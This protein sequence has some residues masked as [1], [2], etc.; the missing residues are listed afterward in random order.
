MTWLFAFVIVLAAGLTS[1][2]LAV[3]IWQRRSSPGALVFALLMLAVAEWSVGYALEIAAPGEAAKLLWAKAQYLGIV[4]VPLAWL[5]FAL[6]YS[7]RD[8]ALTGHPLRIA[9]LCTVPLVTLLLVWTNEA[10]HLVWA[11]AEVHQDGPFPW[12]HVSYGVWFWVHVAFSYA[13][14]LGGTVSLVLVL[15]RSPQLYRQQAAALLT[16]MLAPWVGNALYVFDLNPAAPLDLTPFAF[17][18]SGLALSWGLFRFRLLDVV[19]VAHE[20]VVAGMSDGVIVLDAQNRVVE[21]NPAA[22]SFVGMAA[23][24]AIGKPAGQVL[25]AWP[26]L[27]ERYQDASSA[28]AEISVE[29][30]EVRRMYDL[31]IS[32]L[33]SP[34]GRLSGRLIVLRDITTRKQAEEQLRLANAGMQATANAIVITDREGHITWVNPAFTRLTGYKTE[35]ALGQNPRL[36]RSGEHAP[37]FYQE[38]WDTIL[39]GQVWHGELVNRRKDGELYIEEQS[40]TPVRDEAGQISHF[41]GVKQD[42]TARKKA[43]EELHAQKQLS[44]NL[45]AVA[46]A[47]IERPTLEDTLQNALDVAIVL[48]NAE[49]GSL[50]LLDGTGAVT[51]SI[52]IRGEVESDQR[53]QILIYVME[54]G[55]AGWVFQH[56]Q[57]A[58]IADAATDDRWVVLPDEP[59]DVH[60]VLAV[61]IWSGTVVTGIIT[62]AHSQPAYFDDEHVVMMQAAADQMALAVRNAQIFDALRR[63]AD[64]QITLYQVLS[65]VSEQLLPEAVARTA[66]SSVVEFAGWPHAAIALP[67]EDG[68]SWHFVAAGGLIEPL[69]GT[70]FP[71]ESGVVGQA[72]VTAKTQHLADVSLDPTYFAMHPS[73]RSELAVPIE[74]G[75]RVLGVIDLESERLAAFNADDLALAE[76]LA[77]AIALGLDNALLFQT[78]QEE[79]SRLQALITSSQDGIVFVSAADRRI[80]VL[81]QAA[82]RLL[83]L[84]GEPGDWLERPIGE[85]LSPLRRTAPA[86]VK[87]TLA[88]MRR[89]QK[90]DEPPGEGEYEV[91]PYIIR[92]LN[93][94]V[95]IGETPLGRLLMLRDVSDER[96][97]ERLREDVTRTMVHDLRNPLTGIITSLSLLTR[98][99]MGE[100]QEHQREV[101]EIAERSATRM[102]ELVNSILDVSRLESG[103]MPIQREE[104]AVADL[105][106]ET[107]QLQ[108]AMAGEKNVRL[109][110]DV[111]FSLPLAWA[112]AGMI[113]RVLQNLVG[114]AVKFTPP[115]GSV[116]VTA[117]SE[118][119][120]DRS[121]LLVTVSDNG[122]GVPAKIRDRLFEKFVTGGQEER[123]SGLGLAFCKL[124]VEA[125]GGRIWIE[126]KPASPDRANGAAFTFSLPTASQD[127]V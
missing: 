54:H 62:L 120:P 65:T 119:G 5:V 33:T 64:R 18:I 23:S 99:A 7:R 48:T 34:R 9:A 25:G 44:E 6:Q 10:H 89:V 122:P 112:D 106:A 104:F 37:T 123:G 47:T 59:Y 60:S 68:R 49:Y 94:P 87:T 90:G 66:V 17:T 85:A 81:N 74:R 29:Q 15:I 107:I 28:Q 75:G 52:M 77:E 63:M 38:M 13:C 43:E 14:L 51:D 2:A 30:A 124:A 26:E 105:I 27:V 57:V 8:R 111:P 114:N 31:R 71:M 24:A 42:I 91:P 121:Q 118:A 21:I 98:G 41:I 109:E 12:L 11:H 39:A 82:L 113:G 116:R 92:W 86:V 53:Q 55:L 16:G 35:E 58:L 110:S 80:R 40:I 56:R 1:A 97:A 67:A 102:K 36:L 19:P 84:P 93:L 69:V 126:D 76:S 20:A 50:F 127:V 45:V 78:V 115:G 4:G 61:P 70:T 96:A 72:F 103:R 32:P 79:R 46:R 117:T 88:E 100:I 108:A 3:Y 83:R 101:L 22:Q 125:H 73:I 95:M